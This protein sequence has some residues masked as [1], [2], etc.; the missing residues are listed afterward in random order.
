MSSVAA[1]GGA[2]IRQWLDLRRANWSGVKEGVTG[3]EWAF[4]SVEDLAYGRSEIPR[5]RMKIVNMFPSAGHAPGSKAE[6]PALIWR[7]ENH[8]VRRVPYRC[9]RSP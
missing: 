9:G 3:D 6:K 4:H 8:A 5:G 7:N 2:R 1:W